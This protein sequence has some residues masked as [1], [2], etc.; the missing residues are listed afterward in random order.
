MAVGGLR[1]RAGRHRE[2]AAVRSADYGPDRSQRKGQATRVRHGLGL[3][4]G[5]N[6]G[7]GPLGD[8]ERVDPGSGVTMG[9]GVG[10]RDC[11]G[12]DRQGSAGEAV[13]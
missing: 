7:D 2:I 9:I 3:A 10:A 1:D 6:L 4:E 13:L 11:V 5:R 12:P 8:R